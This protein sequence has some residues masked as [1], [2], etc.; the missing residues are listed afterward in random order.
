MGEKNTPAHD[1]FRHWLRRPVRKSSAIRGARMIYPLTK[2]CVFGSSFLASVLIHLAV[3][4]CMS[5]SMSYQNRFS[6]R[7]LIPISLLEPPQE[8]TAPR[9]RDED[10]PVAKKKLTPAPQ[11][12]APKPPLRSKDEQSMVAPPAPWKLEEQTKVPTAST[13]RLFSERV[14]EHNGGAPAGASTFSSTAETGVIPRSGS[15]GGGSAVAGLGRA[16]GTPGLPA[17]SGLLGTNREAKPIQTARATYPPMA[18]RMGMESDVTLQIEVDPAGNVT[19]AEIAKS[20]GA[21]FD[22]EALKAVKQS[23]FEPA[24]RK[25]HSVPAEFIYIYRFRLHR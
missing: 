19:K 20:G 23:R 7:E 18:L 22:E 25:G 21:G 5:V 2:D 14:S 8:K 17:S 13:E 9:V 15:A 12:Q 6:T 11:Q 10:T 24:Q 16:N 1:N 4:I 3:F